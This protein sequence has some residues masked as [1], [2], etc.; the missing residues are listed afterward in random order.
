MGGR[1]LSHSA[2]QEQE[3]PAGKLRLGE[4]GRAWPTGS[5]RGPGAAGIDPRG[6]EEPAWAVGRPRGGPRGL[7]GRRGGGPPGRQT[8]PR[9]PRLRV[10][11]EMARPGSCQ[12]D[13]HGGQAAKGKVSRSHAILIILLSSRGPRAPAAHARHKRANLQG[14]G[15]REAGFRVAGP[16]VGLK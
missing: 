16:H 13:W 7:T 6:D 1:G 12:E 3:A 4:Q 9:P 10:G 15:W 5:S 11:S 8:S 2:Y 14:P